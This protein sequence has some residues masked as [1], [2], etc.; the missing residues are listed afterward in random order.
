MYIFGSCIYMGWCGALMYWALGA[1][2]VMYP[3]K[4]EE[5]DFV[6]D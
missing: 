5:E 2:M 3:I 4:E 6:E 1:M